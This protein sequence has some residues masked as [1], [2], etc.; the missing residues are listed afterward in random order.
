MKGPKGNLYYEGTFRGKMSVFIA[1]R[2]DE[3]IADSKTG[4]DWLKGQG[5]GH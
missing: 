1:V 4:A 2:H 3:Y 5:N